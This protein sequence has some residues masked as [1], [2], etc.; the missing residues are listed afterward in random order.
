M[1]ESC[2]AT[3]GITF[4]GSA[5]HPKKVVARINKISE[6]L[7]ELQKRYDAAR[8]KINLYCTQPTLEEPV[9]EEPATP[10]FP[11]CDCEEDYVEY[12]QVNDSHITTE[13]L[14]YLTLIEEAIC[15]S[16]EQIK[17]LE[18]QA[19]LPCDVDYYVAPGGVGYYVTPQQE[20]LIAPQP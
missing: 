8:F 11:V 20:V 1:S 9:V 3:E 2:V 10:C 12:Y 19:A 16:E 4:I 7:C 17:E 18:I 13:L 15:E 14:E 6:K 5:D